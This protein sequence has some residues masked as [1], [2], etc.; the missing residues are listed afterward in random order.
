LVLENIKNELKAKRR[1][2]H[3]QETAKTILD[4]TVLSARKMQGEVGI[5]KKKKGEIQRVN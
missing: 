3:S 4:L 5:V 2:S 1:W